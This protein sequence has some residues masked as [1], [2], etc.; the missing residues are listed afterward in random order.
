MRSAAPASLLATLLASGVA[1]AQ[2]AEP[3]VAATEAPPARATVLHLPP[4]EA[5]AGE[6]LRLAAVIDDAWTEAALVVRFRT[7]GQPTWHDA[8][9]ERSSAGGYYATIP[10]A[11]VRR[12]G[13]E[14]F[15]AGRTPAGAET[16]HF[17]DPGQPHLVRVEPTAF[18]RWQEHERRRLGGHDSTASAHAFAHD[19]GNRFDKEDY[20]GRAELDF[21]HRLV[22]H[23]YAISFGFGAIEGRTPEDATSD[24]FVRRRGARYGY[25]GA[26]LR[27]HDSVWIDGRAAIGVDRDEFITGARAQLTLG[28]PWRSSVDLGAEV[29]ENLGPTLWV[30]LQWDTVPPFLMGAAIV[31]TDMP[32]A[33]LRNGSFIVYDITYPVTER[34]R[35]R[36]SL[37][38]GAR[39]GP[40]NFGGGLG[41]EMAF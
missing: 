8:L 24:A 31:K 30:R 1:I 23:L 27:L 17:A 3:R 19:F 22:D 21:T 33:E 2:P 7:A 38:F 18:E 35:L 15:I 32:D 41:T 39:D 29:M 28:K 6:P 12:P 34:L 16:L 40:G 37:S 10:A 25:G 4:S 36:G 9:F 26:T 11:A 14:Y 13:L 20:Y 5:D